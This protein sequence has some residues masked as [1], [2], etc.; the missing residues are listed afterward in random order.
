M[1]KTLISLS[2][3]AMFGSG[4][5][6]AVYTP[7][8]TTTGNNFT[9]VAETNGLTGGTNDVTFTWDGTYRTAVVTDKTYNATLSSPTDFSGKIWTAHHMNVYAPGTYTFY[10][11]CTVAQNPTCGV[12]PAY[13]LIVGAGQVGAHMLFNWSTSTNIDVVLLWEM[14]NSWAGTGT[15]SAFNAGGSNTITTLW[16]GVSIDTNIDPDTY[17]GTKMIDGPFIGQS[18]NFNVNGIHA[19]AVPAVSTTIP[20]DDQTG[21]TPVSAS[22]T[23]TYQVTFNESMDLATI[24]TGFL[25][26]SPA[27]GVS[28]TAVAADAS[29]KVFTFTVNGLKSGTTYTVTLN[30]NNLAA[31]DAFNVNYLFPQTTRK[32]TTSPVT[33]SS[34]TPAAGEP[35]AS[36]GAGGVMTYTVT[37]TEP[38]NPGSVAAGFLSFVPAPV[39]AVGAPAA[40]AGNKIFDFPVTLNS[41]T[42]Y[43]VT[44]NAGPV[45]V[46][47]TAVTLPSPMSFTSGVAD[48][49]S[50]TVVAGSR[51]PAPSSTAAS[52]RPTFSVTFSETMGASTG[53]SIQAV[54]VSNSSVACTPFVA[55]ATTKTF[56]CTPTADLAYGTDYSVTVGGDALRVPSNAAAA[57]DTV[58]NNLITHA[59]N[60]W[61]FTVRQQLGSVANPVTVPGTS[62]KAIT[63]VGDITTLTT[64]PTPPSGVVPI[65]RN[66]TFDADFVRY[67]IENIPVG[68]TTAAVRLTFQNSIAGKKLYKVDYATPNNFSEIREITGVE[69]INPGEGCVFK[70]RADIDDKTVDMTITDNGSCDFNPAQGTIDDPVDPA[71][72]IVATL[73]AAS[74]AGGGG[75]GCSVDPS[76]KDASLLV[77]LLAGLGYVGWR[78]R[79]G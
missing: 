2:V 34:T 28:V 10:T 55:D 75:G 22:A 16:D 42:P 14:N 79:R 38:M 61:T 17:S 21:A 32:F 40:R 68:T 63:S 57:Q 51:L 76:G 30:A 33:V 65:N 48:T 67:V 12:G 54:K 60:T 15:V 18:A 31:A 35:A 37:F 3:A 50:P 66:V 11:G 47:G 52:L 20:A 8:V 29:N 72:P 45:D 4:A 25:S 53:A 27:A 19:P 56:T 44:F 70:R 5:A 39:V 77:V 73:G 41:T 36:L 78:R 1:K 6:Q 43:T 13:T 49:T 71:A 9:M 46:T 62:V 69:T 7:V 26:F 74:A 58:G 64:S 23:A 24:T 59:N